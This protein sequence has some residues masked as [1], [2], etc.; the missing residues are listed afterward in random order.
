MS[1][2][3]LKILENTFTH[4]DYSNNP[5][6]PVSFSK[7]VEWDR[8]VS[9]EEEL[10]FYTDV[11]IDRPR[12]GH[13]RRIAW[14]IEPYV[15]Q[16]H[17]YEKLLNNSDDFEY[18]LVNDKKLLD[19]GDKFI[20][21]PFGGCWIETEN[22]RTN[23][24]KSKLVSMIT[25]GKKNV[26]DHYKRH[27]IINRYGNKID[28]MGRGYKPIEPISV[29]LIDYMFHIA[30]ENESRDYHF[31]EK[32]INP[33]MVG[34]IPIYYGMPSVKEY[35]YEGGMIVF[36]EVDELEDI[37]NSLSYDLYKKMLPDAK[38]NF[39]IAENYILSED[40]MY[41]NIFKKMSII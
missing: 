16:P 15:K 33:I 37:L 3:K 36:N 25:S 26:A 35:F 40:W 39:K 34:S 30:M 6:P 2:I 10:V 20:Y 32:L 8:N 11:N 1:K 22:R 28:V 31:S 41:E 7:Y 19:A 4:C 13:K 27:E 24:D 18:V 29:G 9:D 17:R 23:H 12:P 14:L 38:R 5:M 21:Y